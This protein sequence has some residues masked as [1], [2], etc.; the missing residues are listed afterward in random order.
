MLGLTS[1]RIITSQLWTVMSDTCVSPMK[2]TLIQWPTSVCLQDTSDSAFVGLSKW[3]C[4]V[5][6]QPNESISLHQSLPAYGYLQA[7]VSA[8]TVS[9]AQRLTPPAVFCLNTTSGGLLF[10]RIPTASSS[11]SRSAF[12]SADFVASTE[13]WSASRSKVAMMTHSLR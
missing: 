2:M 6:L 7:Q 10:S 5:D 4:T 13:L 3:Y 11:I 12:C 9:M 8:R 1:S